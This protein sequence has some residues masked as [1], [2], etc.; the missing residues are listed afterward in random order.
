MDLLTEISN[1]K[2][3]KII[4]IKCNQF[5]KINYNSFKMMIFLFNLNNNKVFIKWKNLKKCSLVT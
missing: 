4:F 2:T 1:K 3:N 5:K